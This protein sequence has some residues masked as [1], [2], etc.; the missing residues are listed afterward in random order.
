MKNIDSPMSFVR[1]YAMR[2]D[3]SKINNNEKYTAI[4][5]LSGPKNTVN[6]AP[7]RAKLIK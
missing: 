5:E 4:D 3:A 2:V 1:P 7:S 6:M